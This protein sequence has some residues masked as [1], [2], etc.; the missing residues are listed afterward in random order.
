RDGQLRKHFRNGRRNDQHF[1]AWW[2]LYIYAFY[3][4]LGYKI[5][6]H[7]TLPNGKEPDFLI[8]RDG[9]GAY[10][11]CKAVVERTRSATEA[12][13]LNCTDKASHPDFILELDS[14][15]ERTDEPS[16]AKIRSRIEDW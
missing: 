3:R 2:E 14:D 15:Q 16:C 11:E 12:A 10:V 13:I 4:Q 9:E 5:A 6:V 8:T 7:P 1:G